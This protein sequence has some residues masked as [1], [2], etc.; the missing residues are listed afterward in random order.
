MIKCFRK[1]FFSGGRSFV[2]VS[3]S[4]VMYLA[5]RNGRYNHSIELNL[6]KHP[7]SAPALTQNEKHLQ[8]NDLDSKDQLGS[9]LER[10]AW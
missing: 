9:S 5:L 10:L 4:A 6:L 3:V 8:L 2:D 7:H 1:Y